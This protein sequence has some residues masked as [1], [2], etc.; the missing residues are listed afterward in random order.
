MSA[1]IDG[2]L[3][4]Q[5]FEIIRDRIGRIIADEMANQYAQSANQ[6]L[7]VQNWI[8]RFIPFDETEMP[9]INVM[10]AEGAYGGQTAIQMDGT[11]R[12]YV[13][14]YHYSKSQKNDG[15]DARAMR[16][17]HQLLGVC[18]AIIHDPRYRTLGFAPPFIMNRH[19]EGIQI[20]DPTQR[21]SQQQDVNHVVMGRLTV[22]VKAPEVTQYFVKPKNLAW[23]KTT[24]NLGSTSKGYLWLDQNTSTYYA[25]NAGI[26]DFS[27]DSTF[28]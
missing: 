5:A 24:V 7:N 9:S 28:E 10:F 23:F 2:V 27:F 12:Y 16:K 14:I 19:V 21:E 6:N 26:F 3:Q 13:D 15:G 8:E 22:S 20:K 18:R 11:Y 4:P 17:L 1:I 25:D